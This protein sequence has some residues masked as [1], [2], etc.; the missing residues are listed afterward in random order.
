[1]GKLLRLLFWTALLLGVVVGVARLFAIRWW[2]VPDD[3]PRLAAS[4]TPTLRGGDWVLLWRAT[5]PRYGGL[6]VCTDPEDDS[7]VVIGRI[8]GE[9][10]D[11][12]A[13]DG[14]RVRV[15]GREAETETVCSPPTFR[16]ANP[17]T[18]G[19]VEQHCSQEAMGGVLH[20]RGELDGLR[21]PLQTVRSVG[22]GRVFL[23]SDNRAYSY[24]SRNYGSVERS[25]CQE[26]VFFR[27]VGKEGFM[28]SEGRL[29]YVP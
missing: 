19:E 9:G 15:N 25:T 22:D 23:L 11:L 20:R 10:G 7:G 14:A 18:G 28:D 6:V 2:Q 29:E 16:V 5:P 17:S 12:L 21:Q 26:S 4:I 27:L 8:V 1:M 3:D 13:I 24:D